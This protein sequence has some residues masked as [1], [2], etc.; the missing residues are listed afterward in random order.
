VAVQSAIKDYFAKSTTKIVN[1]K[2]DHEARS[3]DVYRERTYICSFDELGNQ[4]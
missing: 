4:V 2:Y 1:I 3:Y